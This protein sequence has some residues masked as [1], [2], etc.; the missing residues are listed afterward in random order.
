MVKARGFVFRK[1]SHAN[2]INM[3]KLVMQF[4]ELYN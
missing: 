1:K 2:L 4:V 3:K